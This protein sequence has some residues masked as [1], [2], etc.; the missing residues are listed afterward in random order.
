M[1]KKLTNFMT[2][3]RP[4]KSIP[5]AMYEREEGGPQSQPRAW[6]LGLVGTSVE[7]T[8]TNAGQKST[9]FFTVS[10]K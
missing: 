9:V 8:Y 5:S 6:M 10:N 1:E 7:R 4:L 3:R 2:E